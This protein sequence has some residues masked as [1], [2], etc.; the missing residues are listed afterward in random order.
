MLK[1]DKPKI[2]AEVQ[3][4]LQS[5]K[6]VNFID[7]TGMDIKSQQALK[8]ELKAADSVMLVAKNTL[9]KLA[10]K[11]AKLPSEVLEDAIL[12]GQTAVILASNDPVAPI[13]VIGKF[14]KL[15]N[16]PQFKAGVIEGI[17]Q[18][19]DGLIAISKL[20]SKEVLVGQTVGNI[21]SPMYMLISNLE[22]TIQELIGTIS[23][24]VG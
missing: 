20:P 24:K 5:A 12:R 15:T 10:S 22:G 1:S 6:C 7:F 3:E 21:A 8:R 18:N 14:S 2:V 9:L 13:Q 23:A 11:A 19:K 4:K 17:F 16:T